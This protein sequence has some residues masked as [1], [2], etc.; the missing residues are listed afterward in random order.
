MNIEVQE[1]LPFLVPLLILQLILVVTALI[2]I[3]RQQHFKYLNRIAWIIIVIIL[4]IFGPIL[5]FVLE[6]K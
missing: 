1:Y 5:Y 4:N 3:I 2:M 6:R